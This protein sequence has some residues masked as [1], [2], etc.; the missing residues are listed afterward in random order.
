MDTQTLRR[1]FIEPSNYQYFLNK[2][3]KAKASNTTYYNY[4]EV[5]QVD[6]RITLI[7]K[8]PTRLN[9]LLLLL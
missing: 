8:I 3:N 1:Y 4:Y 9:V 7:F 5:A 6:E 2:A